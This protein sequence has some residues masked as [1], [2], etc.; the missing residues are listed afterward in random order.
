M[1]KEKQAVKL[2][3]KAKGSRPY[4]FEDP[5][6]DKV[7]AMVMGLAGEVSVLADRV[8]TLERVLSE[9]GTLDLAKIDDYQPD[10]AV[11][12]ARDN[13]REMMLANVM[14]IILQ[15]EEDPDNGEPNDAAYMSIVKEV[16]G[17]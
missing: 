7:V 15:N 5:A 2:I 16:E 10:V 1:S 9:H 12:S 11:S 6:I 8:D 4:F 13:R 14:R 17:A 3:K